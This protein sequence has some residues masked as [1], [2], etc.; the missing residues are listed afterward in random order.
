MKNRDEHLAEQSEDQWFAVRRP[1]IITIVLLLAGIVTTW[2]VN[3]YPI[4]GTNT[5]P[6][7]GIYQVKQ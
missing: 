1:A 5:R 6:A 3:K 2:F 7:A 4:K